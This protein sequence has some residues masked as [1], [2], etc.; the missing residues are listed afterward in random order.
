M[1]NQNTSMPDMERIKS[2]KKIDYLIDV[3]HSLF[4]MLFNVPVG[5]Y[6]TITLNEKVETLLTPPHGICNS[7]VTF[8]TYS[9]CYLSWYISQVEDNCGCA[10][11]FAKN[12]LTHSVQKDKQFFSVFYQI[13][14]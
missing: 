1:L 9:Q 3:F 11:F 13:F 4:F 10:P 7:S 6:T 12:R 2:N 5:A 14:S 8:N